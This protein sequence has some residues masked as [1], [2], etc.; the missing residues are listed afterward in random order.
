M[1][2]RQLDINSNDNT[3]FT[4]EQCNNRCIMCCQ[5]P[6]RVD[7]IDRLFREN[8]QRI[9]NAPKDLPMIALTGGEPT[10]MGDKMIELVRLIRETLPDTEIH[11]LSNGRTFANFD[12][13]KKLGEVADGHVLMGIP[14]HSDYEYDHD[15]IA[16]AR[17]AYV[18]TMK[19]LYNLA[20]QGIA[21]ELRIVMNKLNYLRFPQMAE[22]IHK[23]LSFVNWTAFMGMERTGFAASKADRIWIEP[24]EY[25][26]NLCKAIQY[27]DDFCHDV[28]IYNL[29]LCL[30][31]E[32]YHAFAEKSISDWKNSYLPICDTCTKK[33]CCCGFFTTASQPF[34]EIKPFK[35]NEV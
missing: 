22:F 32:E 14:L 25:V 15:V 19:G 3:L 9:L 20:M 1:R 8:K 13:A 11:I 12:Y 29:P 21:I 30:I 35:E 26:L 27:L 16:G 24:K 31:P 4:T 23:N 17:G 28:C 6:K 2:Q 18:E 33:G 7:D 10:L 34:E 5:P